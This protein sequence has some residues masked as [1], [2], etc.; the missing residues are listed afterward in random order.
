MS[1]LKEKK[2]II[3]DLEIKLKTEENSTAIF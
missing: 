3:K 2:A 1:K